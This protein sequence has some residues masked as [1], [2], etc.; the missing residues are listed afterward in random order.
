MEDTPTLGSGSHVHPEGMEKVVI[1]IGVDLISAMDGRREIV[2]SFEQSQGIDG[3]ANL[4]GALD[5][6]NVHVGE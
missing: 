1:I 2:G 5:I 4:P 6:R 3:I